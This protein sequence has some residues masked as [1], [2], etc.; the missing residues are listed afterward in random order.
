VTAATLAPSASSRCT[1]A[2]PTDP[3]AP[4]TKIMTGPFGG[5]L[6]SRRL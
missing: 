1:V 3:V 5:G 4:V 2:R 6:L